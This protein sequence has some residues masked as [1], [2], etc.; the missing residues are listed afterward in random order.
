LLAVGALLLAVG[1]LGLAM[2]TVHEMQ[3][4]L[5]CVSAPDRH[6]LLQRVL[7]VVATLTDVPVVQVC[8]AGAACGVIGLRRR[9]RHRRDV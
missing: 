1:L 8:L 2:I 7:F 3:T 9:A 5:P 4:W 6:F